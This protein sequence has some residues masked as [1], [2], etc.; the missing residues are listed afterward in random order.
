MEL[1]DQR[2]SQRENQISDKLFYAS[3]EAI[4]GKFRGKFKDQHRRL[5]AAVHKCQHAAY[6]NEGLKYE[7]AEERAR[8]CF[9]PLLLVRRHASTI[10]LNAKDEFESCINRARQAG[11]TDT[12]RMKCFTVY[13]DELKKQIPKVQGFYDGYLQNYSLKDGSLQ[14]LPKSE[15]KEIAAIKQEALSLGT[16]KSSDIL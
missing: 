9:L 7:Q 11:A 15:A 4:D 16:G 1:S 13:K 12:V 8:E 2:A 3:T 10:M 14:P 5:K 6:S